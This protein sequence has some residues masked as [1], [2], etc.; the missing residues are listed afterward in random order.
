M[1]NGPHDMARPGVETM[2]Q[3]FALC[4]NLDV[5]DTYFR[6]ANNALCQT[7]LDGR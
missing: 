5:V 6:G 7:A 1:G 2:D 4:D 3:N